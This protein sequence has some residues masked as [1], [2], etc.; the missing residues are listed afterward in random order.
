MMGPKEYFVAFC[1][2][3]A[4]N[5]WEDMQ[6]FAD[7]VTVPLQATITR[8]RQQVDM[9][10][11]LNRDL[12]KRNASLRRDNHGLREL[13]KQFEDLAASFQK[14]ALDAIN[15]RKTVYYMPG[16]VTLGQTDQWWEGNRH[17]FT[18]TIGS[19]VSQAIMAFANEQREKFEVKTV[20]T[21][22]TSANDIWKWA[23]GG[24]YPQPQ[25][26]V[27]VEPGNTAAKPLRSDYER[28]ADGEIA[29]F[30]V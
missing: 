25:V 23:N 17:R 1:L 9:C 20:E 21:P 2:G 15:C 13:T 26:K 8:L 18:S 14:V 24:E 7:Y 10:T 4:T 28:W 30:P 19:D 11:T 16:K 12:I 3:T 6:A 27:S 22:K 29:G 5:I